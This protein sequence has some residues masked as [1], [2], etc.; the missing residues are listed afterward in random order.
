MWNCLR[1]KWQF[2]ESQ[3]VFFALSLTMIIVIEE[4]IG[5]SIEVYECR[6]VGYISK[7]ACIDLAMCLLVILMVSCRKCFCSL[8]WKRSPATL[9]QVS[10]S[11]TNYP[12]SLYF[13]SINFI[14]EC[15]VIW[16]LIVCVCVRVGV[17]GL[18]II[19]LAF[20]VFIKCWLNLFGWRV[21]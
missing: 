14:P 1:F 10:F 7:V 21:G 12:I 16:A 8:A 9:M 6:H 4:N 5:F 3:I 2:S 17:C 15:R 13:F 20:A 11:I 18:M 19:L